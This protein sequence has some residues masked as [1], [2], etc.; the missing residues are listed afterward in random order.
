MLIPLLYCI[1]KLKLSSFCLFKRLMLDESPLIYSCPLYNTLEY[2]YSRHHR[3]SHDNLTFLLLFPAKKSTFSTYAILPQLFDSLCL[4]DDL[5]SLRPFQVS[6]LFLVPFF[7]RKPTLPQGKNK[8]TLRK[9]QT[10]S[11]FTEQIRK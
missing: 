11:G 9:K 8:R 1:S 4:D 10:L 2:Q 6:F 3:P 7:H 5:L